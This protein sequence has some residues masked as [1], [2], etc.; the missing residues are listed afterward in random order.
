MALAADPAEAH[1]RTDLV[2]GAAGP[3]AGPGLE[4]VAVV[5]VFVRCD[6]GA[7]GYGEDGADETEDGADCSDEIQE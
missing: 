2:A 6:E 7:V 5:L 3:S 4:C 1:R